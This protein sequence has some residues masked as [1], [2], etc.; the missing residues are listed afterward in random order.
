MDTFIFHFLFQDTNEVNEALLKRINAH[1]K[2]HLVPSKI[3]DTYFLR[4]AI[5]SRF[6]Q[7]EDIEYSWK[8]I[9]NL[10]DLVLA[11]QKKEANCTS[12]KKVIATPKQNG[13][14]KINGSK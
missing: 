3:N 1:G 8:E 2:I 9:S 10:A 5:C 13:N 7:K 12:D 6:S 11:E 14:V 4:V